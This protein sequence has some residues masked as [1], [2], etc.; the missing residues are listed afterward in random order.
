MPRIDPTLA[1]Y[2]LILALA[3]GMF[4]LIF[5]TMGAIN[6]F[7]GQGLI[8][9]AELSGVS[10]TLYFVYPFLL[11]AAALGS[12]LLYIGK[13]EAPAVGL[14]GLPIVGVVVYYLVLTT[15]R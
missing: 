1:L 2:G 8:W 10:R 12:I 4:V 5:W 7:V 13:Q 6:L 9:Q 15:L 3:G 11:I 14:A